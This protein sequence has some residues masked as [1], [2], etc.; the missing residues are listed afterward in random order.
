MHLQ[1][2]MKRLILLS[3]LLTGCVGGSLK[4]TVPDSGDARNTCDVSSGVI[5]DLVNVNIERNIEAAQTGGAVLGGYIANEATNNSNDITQ[6]VA[7]VAGAAGGSALGNL[8]GQQ[9]LNRDGVELL[10]DVNGSVVSIIQQDDASVTFQKGDAVWV[11]GATSR[12]RYNSKKC[13]SGTRVLPRS[14]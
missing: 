8:L 2:N 4:P 11:V 7:T 3:F 14:K 6:A 5:I 10:V 13:A 9:M 12:A 1:I